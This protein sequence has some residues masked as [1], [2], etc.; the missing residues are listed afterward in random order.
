MSCLTIN[1]IK[2]KISIL[3]MLI[4]C[5]NYSVRGKKR[6]IFFRVENFRPTNSQEYLDCMNTLLN[7]FISE[8]VNKKYAKSEFL[9]VMERIESILPEKILSLD[10]SLLTERPEVFI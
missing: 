8:F 3:G 2:L 5:T 6:T 9:T 1:S 10:K 4:L 7:D